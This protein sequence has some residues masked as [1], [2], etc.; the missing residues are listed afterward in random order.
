MA[1]SLRR[2]LRKFLREAQMGEDAD[3]PL[4]W[5]ASAQPGSDGT[6]VPGVDV[7]PSEHGAFWLRRLRGLATRGLKGVPPV[8]GDADESVQ[9]AI[10]AVLQ[11]ARW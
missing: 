10:A 9:G 8:T 4:D 2:A 5:G 7:G 3:F 1:H 6:E 11:G